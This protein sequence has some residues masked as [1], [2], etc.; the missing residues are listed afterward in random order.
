[1][2][3]NGFGCGVIEHLNDVGIK[4]QVV[5]VGWPDQFIEHGAVDI[6]RKKHGLTAQAAVEKILPFV[7]AKGASSKPKSAA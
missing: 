5:R 4:T 6:L 3:H 1:V 7:K 2:L